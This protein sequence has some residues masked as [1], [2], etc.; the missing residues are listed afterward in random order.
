MVPKITLIQKVPCI[1]CNN[2]KVFDAKKNNQNEVIIWGTGKPIR[3]WLYVEDGAESLIK[4]I[5]LSEGHQFF[6]IGV[7]KGIS[8]IDLAEL[9]R[10]KLQW[11]GKFVLDKSKPDGVLEKKLMEL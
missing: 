10:K 7:E 6:N 9:I 4:S 1:R 2:K 3:E 8:I 11:K 5:E